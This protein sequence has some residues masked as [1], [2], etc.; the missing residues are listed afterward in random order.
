MLNAKVIFMLCLTVAG[1]NQA[2]TASPTPPPRFQIQ[3]DKDGGLWR[4]DTMNGNVSY[5]W[6]AAGG[7]NTGCKPIAEP[8][9]VPSLK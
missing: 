2:P 3:P 4:V 1:C 6:F 7:T 5:C 8:D 9:I